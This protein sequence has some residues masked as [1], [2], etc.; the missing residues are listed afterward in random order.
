MMYSL[1]GDLEGYQQLW[2]NA[3]LCGNRVSLKMM[4]KD[5]NLPPHFKG[6]WDCDVVSII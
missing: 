1:E 5:Q 3:V 6:A 4:I 2:R